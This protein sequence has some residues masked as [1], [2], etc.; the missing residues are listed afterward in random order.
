[1]SKDPIGFAGGDA[2]LFAYCG[3]DPVRAVDPSGLITLPAPSVP[4]ALGV[5]V[6][7]PGMPSVSIPLGEEQGQQAVDYWAMEAERPGNQWWQTAGANVGL[8]LSSLW[9]PCS[10][11]KTATT[12]T[13]AVG[14]DKSAGAWSKSLSAEAM[15]RLFEPYRLSDG[16]PAFALYNQGTVFRL[17]GHMIGNRKSPP[18]FWA[19]HVDSRALGLKHWPWS[20]WGY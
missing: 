1:V 14:L 17:E 13:L 3:G 16:S 8:G 10:S 6:P 11:D 19:P 4:V 15:P 7:I 5:Q 9:T 18:R 20:N 2:D 12:L